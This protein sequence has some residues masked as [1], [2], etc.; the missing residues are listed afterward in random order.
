M[1]GGPA[2]DILDW[3]CVGQD[4]KPELDIGAQQ[5]REARPFPKWAGGNRRLVGALREHMPRAMPSRFALHAE[6]PERV[7]W[8]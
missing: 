5:R 8:P 6:G 7:L 1:A 4:L 3:L 2:V